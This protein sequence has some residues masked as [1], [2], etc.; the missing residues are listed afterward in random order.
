MWKDEHLHKV[1]E[2]KKEWVESVVTTFKETPERL[3]SFTT[4]SGFEISPLSTPIDIRDLDYTRDIGFPGFYPFTRGIQPSM[5]RGRLWTMRMFSG[6]GGAEETTSVSS[7]SC[8]MGN[9]ALRRVPL[10]D[11]DG[12]RQ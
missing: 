6:L 11:L 7:I 10:P 5:Y 8:V 3:S 12:L 4:L 2:E 9:R 1:E